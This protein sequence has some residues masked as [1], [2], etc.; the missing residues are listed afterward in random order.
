MVVKQKLSTDC[1]NNYQSC[2]DQNFTFVRALDESPHW[3]YSQERNKEAQA[4]LE[5][6]ANWNRCNDKLT[7]NVCTDSLQ[8]AESSGEDNTTIEH[9]HED[10]NCQMIMC[11]RHMMTTIGICIFSW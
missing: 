3:L 7:V 9:R 1:F 4:I 2:F 10:S 8:S 11:N 5:K 6:I